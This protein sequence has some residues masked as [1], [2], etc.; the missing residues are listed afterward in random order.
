MTIVA[1]LCNLGIFLFTCFI[2]LT[3]GPQEGPLALLLLCGRC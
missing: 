2:L 1:L 3:D